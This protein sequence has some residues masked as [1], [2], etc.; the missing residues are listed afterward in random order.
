MELDKADEAMQMSLAG[1]EHLGH[2]VQQFS[3]SAWDLGL[4][5]PAVSLASM[6]SKAALEAHAMLEKA[7]GMDM[8]F[9]LA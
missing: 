6:V 3:A 2:Y 9:L 5:S 4:L 7:I 1:I 8:N